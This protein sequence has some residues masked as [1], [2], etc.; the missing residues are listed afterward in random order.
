M[1]E[2]NSKNFLFKLKRI[3]DVKHQKKMLKI[4]K[5]N[6]D[7]WLIFL[8]IIIVLETLV[9]I[10]LSVKL[11]EK[12]KTEVVLALQLAAKA[13][14]KVPL[15]LNSTDPPFISKEKIENLEKIIQKMNGSMKLSNPNLLI[16]LGNVEYTTGNLL[17]ALTYFNEALEQAKSAKDSMTNAI[18]LGNIGL[19]YKA[20]G[21]IDT[22]LK[23][24]EDALKIFIK[25]KIVYGKDIVS[26]AIK[27]LRN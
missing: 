13:L 7:F 14:D 1:C 18:C 22:A 6:K 20:K 10:F 9:L 12:E 17:M 26:N 24:H 27:K 15:P 11:L 19:V 25:F 16:K 2:S 4:P 5:I 23:Y 3:E 21:D 8:T